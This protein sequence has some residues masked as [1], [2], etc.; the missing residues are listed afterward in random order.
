MNKGYVAFVAVLSAL[1]AIMMVVDLVMTI[2]LF[3][4]NFPNFLNTQFP[5]FV[6][7]PIPLL[8]V[9]L[10]GTF[11]A[12]WLVFV[13]IAVI[14]FLIFAL[15][16]STFKFENSSLYRLGEF[17]ALN[18]FLSVVYISLISLAGY[19]IVSPI[20]SSTPFYLNFLTITNAGLYEELIS[21]VVYIGLPLFV[22]YAWSTHGKESPSRP[23]KLPWYRA[24]WGGGYKF[25]KPEITALVISSLIFGFAHVTS[26]DLSKVPQAALGG[27][28]LGV[29]Y[30]RFGLYADV[31]FHFSIDSPSLLM[32][33]GYGDPIASSYTNAFIGAFIVVAIV[34]GIVVLIVYVLQARTLYQEKRSG[35]S[36]SEQQNPVKQNNPRN[37]LV[38]KNCGSGRVTFFYDDVYRCDDCGTVFKRDQ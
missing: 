24:I 6:I 33:L 30:L 5:L 37:P 28:L 13:V 19:P 4:P 3:K 32:P 12:Y 15:Y 31:L 36:P 18:Y 21:R 11:T 34:G 35:H 9:Y 1:W 29:L 8:L 23:A 2:I 22:Y 25:G 38:C 26:W 27:L 14:V 10:S 17:F 16:R 7:V 20:S